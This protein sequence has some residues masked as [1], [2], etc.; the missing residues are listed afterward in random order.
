MSVADLVRS[1]FQAYV[2]KDRALIERV[3]GE[4]FSFSSPL[5]DHIGRAA[6]FE[7][8]WANAAAM[9]AVVIE[10]LSVDGDKAFVRYRAELTNGKQFRNV[11]WFRAEGGRIAEVDV[12]FG[13]TLQEASQA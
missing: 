13:R 11:E 5:D 12:Y 10:D 4:P 6:Y 1:A 9:K 7:R 2:D 3:I 8:C